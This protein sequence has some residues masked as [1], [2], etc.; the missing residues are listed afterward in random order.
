LCPPRNKIYGNYLYDNTFNNTYSILPQDF[1]QDCGPWE[2][3][4][5]DIVTNRTG[6]LTNNLT[7]AKD[8]RTRIGDDDII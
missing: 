3:H 4:S 7:I 8:I 1:R 5:Q 2:S 6:L